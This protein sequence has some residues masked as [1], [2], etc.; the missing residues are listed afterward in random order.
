VSERE[1]APVDVSIKRRRREKT[2]REERRKTV[3]VKLCQKL[4]FEAAHHLPRAPQGH[5]CRRTHGHSYVVEVV[6]EGPVDPDSGW[7]LDYGVIKEALAPLHAALDHHCLNDV[8]GLENP[9]SE[10]LAAWIWIRLAP[11]LPLREVRIDETCTS[12]CIYAGE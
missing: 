10:N 9:T 8:P 11:V 6:I 2:G 4:R 5:K 7:L 3:R 12:A 1:D